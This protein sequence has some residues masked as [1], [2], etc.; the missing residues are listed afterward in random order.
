[1]SILEFIGRLLGFE[2]YDPAH[3]IGEGA[4]W[5]EN[6]WSEPHWMFTYVEAIGAVVQWDSNSQVLDMVTGEV[7]DAWN[8][9]E[10]KFR[11]KRRIWSD[12]HDNEYPRPKEPRGWGKTWATRDWKKR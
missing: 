12:E 10:E 11:G 8:C 4:T 5:G 7:M 1:M 9:A 6:D 2:L 3:G